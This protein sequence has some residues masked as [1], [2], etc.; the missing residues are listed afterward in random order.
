MARVA[1]V[2]KQWFHV[3][4]RR[5]GKKAGVRKGGYKDPKEAIKVA[6]S[7]MDRTN[8]VYVKQ[9]WYN[10]KSHYTGDDKVFE[11]S[12]GN[13]WFEDRFSQ[14]LKSGMWNI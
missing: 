13:I 9:C 5:E 10:P 6:M 11:A 7:M 2:R 12:C 3:Y 4:V 1:N 14:E 8:A